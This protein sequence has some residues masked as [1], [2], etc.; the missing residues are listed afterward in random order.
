M[1]LVQI[2]NKTFRDNTSKDTALKLLGHFQGPRKGICLGKSK[3]FD[4]N[5]Y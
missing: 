1:N 5:A 3:A 2:L 4:T